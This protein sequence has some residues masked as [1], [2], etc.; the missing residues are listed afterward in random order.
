MK[1]LKLYVKAYKIIFNS[2][3]LLLHSLEENKVKKA[4]N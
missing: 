1:N 2:Q 4:I 3:L